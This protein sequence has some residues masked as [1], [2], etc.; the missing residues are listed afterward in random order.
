MN[1]PLNPHL[2]LVTVA[3]VGIWVVGAMLSS[4][5][6]DSRPPKPTF[7][8]FLGELDRGGLREVVMRTRDS[9][10]RVTPA[11]GLAYEVGYPPEYGAELVE[12]LRSAEVRFDVKPGG[13]GALG[14]SAAVRAP[15]C[16]DRRRLVARDPPPNRR[17]RAGRRIQPRAR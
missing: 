8:A 7:A 17:R 14:G 13:G 11:E 9:S 4:P 2:I 16:G 15:R 1:R 6:R 12:R 10:V 5:G 3:L